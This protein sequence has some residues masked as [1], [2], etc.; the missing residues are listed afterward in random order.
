MKDSVFTSAEERHQHLLD[1][2]RETDPVHIDTLLRRPAELALA[3]G[4]VH[5][6]L[7][8]L[9]E[10]RAAAAAEVRHVLG[11]AAAAIVGW[12]E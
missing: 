5:A 7:D 1:A 12:P 2:L 11:P 10:R 6:L 4:L 9:D 8:E 3:T